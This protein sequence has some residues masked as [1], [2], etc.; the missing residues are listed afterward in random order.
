MQIHILISNSYHKKLKQLKK[1]KHRS[2]NWL[3]VRA[4]GNYLQSCFGHRLRKPKK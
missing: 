4:I 1:E 2:M 3:V